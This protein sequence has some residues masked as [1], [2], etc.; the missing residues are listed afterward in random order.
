M[1]RRVA[2]NNRIAKVAEQIS[3]T[4]KHIRQLNQELSRY[5]AELR[6]LKIMKEKN[7]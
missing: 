7:I 3:I 6:K 5:R 1:T 2:I 4:E